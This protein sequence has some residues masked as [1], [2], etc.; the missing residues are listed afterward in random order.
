MTRALILCAALGLSACV[1]DADRDLDGAEV[2]AAN[3][4]LAAD[5]CGEGQVKSVDE[6]GFACKTSG[7]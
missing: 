4:R 2:V 5:Q 6:D 7:E 1:I 3:A